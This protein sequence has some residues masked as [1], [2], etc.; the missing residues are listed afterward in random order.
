MSAAAKTTTFLV[1]RVEHAADRGLLFV[2]GRMRPG[3]SV[4]IGHR[5]V[6]PSALAGPIAAVES[7]GPTNSVVDMEIGLGF[8]CSDREQ[9]AT[10]LGLP[11]VGAKLVIE[12]PPRKPVIV[13]PYDPTWPVTF[14]E[15]RRVLAVGLGDVALAIHHVGSTAVP[16]LAAKPIID[17]DVEISSRKHLAEVIRR[18]GGLGYRHCGDQGLPGR[19]AFGRD[20]FAEVPRDGSGRLWAAHHLYVC[21]SDCEELRRHLLFRDWLRTHPGRSAEY[22]LLKQRLA[23]AFR[24]DRDSY[25]EGKTELVESIVREAAAA[26]V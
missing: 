24:D 19:E 10:W 8:M 12:P 18:L 21:A 11:L 5:I 1:R 22:G 4:G 9:L 3:A 25:V 23:E 20:D 13:V 17:I 26:R 2:F 15:L 14:E 6:A 16:G 7:L